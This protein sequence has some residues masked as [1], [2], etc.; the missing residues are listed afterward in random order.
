VGS[1]LSERLADD[2]VRGSRWLGMIHVFL[3]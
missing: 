3:G 2:I 1:V